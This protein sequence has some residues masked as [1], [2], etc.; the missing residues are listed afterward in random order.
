MNDR[1]RELAELRTRAERLQ[2]DVERHTAA[3]AASGVVPSMERLAKRPSIVA[4]ATDTGDADA[5]ADDFDGDVFSAAQQETLEALRRE[6]EELDQKRKEIDAQLAMLR[7]AQQAADRAEPVSVTLANVHANNLS[8]YF[9][10][11]GAAKVDHQAFL[12]AAF[13]TECM[14][15]GGL[16]TPGAVRRSAPEESAEAM[17]QR[18]HAQKELL[19]ATMNVTFE[20]INSMSR[21]IKAYEKAGNF[22][23]PPAE[24][25]TAP[26]M[27]AQMMTPVGTMKTC[28]EGANC[29]ALTTL[30]P[31]S[32]GL[33]MPMK[34]WQ[35]EAAF[36][37]F[38]RT[39]VCI[40]TGSMANVTGKCLPCILLAWAQRAFSAMQADPTCSAIAF[41]L[42]VVVERPGGFRRSIIIPCD[43]MP[44]AFP[45]L[46]AHHFVPVERDFVWSTLDRRTGQQVK[47]TERVYGYDFRSDV[48]FDPS[49]Y[50]TGVD[51][52]QRLEMRQPPITTTMTV[53]DP[54]LPGVMLDDARNALAIEVAQ[55]K[56]LNEVLQHLLV[57]FEATV[58]D[59]MCVDA[60]VAEARRAIMA[61]YWNRSLVQA[62]EGLLRNPGLW[63]PRTH[64]VLAA[65]MWRVGLCLWMQSRQELCGNTNL[66]AFLNAH[67]E[68]QKWL[69]AEWM[70]LDTPPSDKEL[71]SADLAVL[72]PEGVC[73]VLSTKQLYP[74]YP[75]P[76]L[77]PAHQREVSV[78]LN[79]KLRT[80]PLDHVRRAVLPK[81]LVEGASP[82]A[83]CR[84]AL[85]SLGELWTRD[86]GLLR[87]AVVSG[88]W[89]LANDTG[90]P[91]IDL[92]LLHSSPEVLKQWIAK[93]I[94]M[95]A[96]Q[97]TFDDS[98]WLLTAVVERWP[99]FQRAAAAQTSTTLLGAL[100]DAA[101][102]DALVMGRWMPDHVEVDEPAR[103]SALPPNAPEWV[104]GL[105][106]WRR[107][108]A[109]FE[110]VDPANGDVIETV[111]VADS[112]YPDALMNAT[113][114]QPRRRS[115]MVLAA[116]RLR[117]YELQRL[118]TKHDAPL[119]TAFDNAQR[120][121]GDEA[122]EAAEPLRHERRDVATRI[123]Q[124]ITSD[125][126]TVVS[127]FPSEFGTPLAP[128]ADVMDAADKAVARWAAPENVVQEALDVDVTLTQSVADTL[129]GP[130]MRGEPRR[131][132]ITHMGVPP[133]ER[134][135]DLGYHT[136]CAL[137]E[138]LEL[139]YQ[140][141]CVD[142]ASDAH[143]LFA[144]DNAPVRPL[145]KYAP[146]GWAVACEDALPD[147]SAYVGLDLLHESGRPDFTSDIQARRSWIPQ[148]SMAMMKACYIRDF[149]ANH[150]QNCRHS[151]YAAAMAQVVLTSVQGTYRHACTTQ[152]FDRVLQ[153]YASLRP[154]N[155]HSSEGREVLAR[156]LVRNTYKA[157]VAAREFQM[158]S[159]HSA[160]SQRE[161]IAAAWPNFPY[162]QRCWVPQKAERMREHVR[163]SPT[164]QA[165]ERRVR[166]MVRDEEPA[167]VENPE[168]MPSATAV[169]R[170]FRHLPQ[171]W[172][173][174]ML[175]L[176][177]RAE[178]ERHTDAKVRS[179]THGSDDSVASLLPPIVNMVPPGVKHALVRYFS[180]TD[181]REPIRLKWFAD[182]GVSKRGL[183]QLLCINALYTAQERPVWIRQMLGQMSR[184]DFVFAWTAMHI[185]VLHRDSHVLPMTW[186]AAQRQEQA[187]KFRVADMVNPPPRVFT[188][189]R[190]C[191]PLGCPG[192]QSYH[193]PFADNG[194][195]GAQEDMTAMDLGRITCGCHKSMHMFDKLVRRVNETPV[196]EMSDKLAAIM[197][198]LEGCQEAAERRALEAD[199]V[200]LRDKLITHQSTNVRATISVMMTRPCNDAPAQDLRVV[201]AMVVRY[202]SIHARERPRAYTACLNCAMPSIYSMDRIGPNGFM[203]GKCNREARWAEHGKWCISCGLVEQAETLP[204][205]TGEAEA[206]ARARRTE[207][208]I[209]GST[210]QARSLKAHLTR[211]RHDHQVKRQT[212]Q[213]SR[214]DDEA[215]EPEPDNSDSL[216][217][218]MASL[219]TQAAVDRRA[220]RKGPK[221]LT[222]R[223]RNTA[224]EL[225]L[226]RSLSS[227]HPMPLK[228][229]MD[230]FS[231]RVVFDD[232]VGGYDVPMCV[233]VCSPCENRV[234]VGTI[235][236][237]N[238]LAQ[239]HAPP[240]EI[241][242]HGV[243]KSLVGRR[244]L[245]MRWRR[246]PARARTSDD[247]A[248]KKKPVAKL[249]MLSPAEAQQLLGSQTQ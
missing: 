199:L 95:V 12:P 246:G 111:R 190:F 227:V 34:Q 119:R 151:E 239:T 18:L 180:Q 206:E 140:F 93:A 149:P 1:D 7:A 9:E 50:S 154:Q 116:L 175:A 167:D 177:C 107:F 32:N 29:L 243:R 241:R 209:Q 130:L 222:E 248:K 194:H 109:V 10:R 102:A 166:E 161:V 147:I 142:D 49:T 5:N 112:L 81:Q 165:S 99:W 33:R 87:A 233:S 4:M 21:C 232:R 144:R 137:F 37:A 247:D 193:V 63:S 41:P 42:D 129:L 94:S 244:G 70:R 25:S 217:A 182:C 45:N 205:L 6:A 127:P 131:R 85:G 56:Q 237:V 179:V 132:L 187:A 67:T 208:Q 115:Y 59:A 164:A 224:S 16:Q 229:R 27:Q 155:S 192:A 126:H 228:T 125:V 184:V 31:H 134:N 54:K 207:H 22:K 64:S 236:L 201:G 72:T 162:V 3:L 128:G 104:R 143:W 195:Y 19:Q 96:L 176:F 15:G 118:A 242:I 79:R 235:S 213:G 136:R 123:R 78:Q 153:M 8:E 68:L 215:D 69:F 152:R 2:N 223:R 57:E 23:V 53:H 38:I 211:A 210:Q 24:K 90:S 159:I 218:P 219:E 216:A 170:V 76:Y 220:A 188:H 221:P 150:A 26:R 172:P 178:N 75:V 101:A 240:E 245:R 103:L 58:R 51:R 173:Y 52:F 121:A 77:S 17:Q 86:S 148:L 11:Y 100:K 135:N 225:Q 122:R 196:A 139:A 249:Q 84:A 160:L 30:P 230:P 62:P 174:Q 113:N 198:A 138:C 39:G 108:A 89:L 35:R 168:S 80:P 47:H 191:H 185:M 204:Q 65:C 238:I 183:A 124:V 120:L 133:S 74:V 110:R 156:Y 60:D 200:R 71:F 20:A 197:A 226:G 40:D 48:L 13:V 181:P 44:V 66:N 141:T 92:A 105:R 43:T 73:A 171:S 83:L 98:V 28:T 36:D 146:L 158:V 186:E 88:G 202:N 212:L 97:T 157:L 117:V 61:S 214:P 145:D 231:W 203:C 106:G 189:M 14:G 55:S 114:P 234:R 46:A 163:D 91:D 82:R 169:P